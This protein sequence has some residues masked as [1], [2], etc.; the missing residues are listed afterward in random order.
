MPGSRAPLRG[1]TP[2]P[3]AYCEG[4][5]SMSGI[6]LGKLREYARTGDVELRLKQTDDPD[7]PKIET[8][9]G[10]WH[11]R[12]VRNLKIEHG[13][14]RSEKKVEYHGAHNEVWK[15]LREAYG[16][17]SGEKA[18]RAGG[19]GRQDQDGNWLTNSNRPLTGRH[20][21]KMLAFG[22]KEYARE[23]A[24]NR[25]IGEWIGALRHDGGGTPDVTLGEKVS[26]PRGTIKKEDA[27]RNIGGD[28]NK[29]IDDWHRGT[30]DKH[31]FLIL[32]V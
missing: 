23:V 12:L 17:E 4:D 32:D 8:R 13:E 31:G 28:L 16:E 27:F 11:G 30:E 7:K 6:N 20:I 25:S 3:W 2:S 19:F 14:D 10:T 29:A 1:S 24:R 9:E 26:Q 22:D 5:T 21:E 18:F 15:A